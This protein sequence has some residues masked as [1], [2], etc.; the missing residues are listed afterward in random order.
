MVENFLK[1]FAKLIVSKPEL[2]SVERKDL[3]DKFSEIIIT[4]DPSDT[5]KII[6]RDGRM[7][8]SIK[9]VISGCKVKDDRSY[10]KLS[11]C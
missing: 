4:A 11:L 8:N 3:E 6:G 7:I 9:T 1:E 10:K 5:G 2:I